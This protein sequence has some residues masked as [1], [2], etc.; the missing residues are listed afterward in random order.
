MIYLRQRIEIE[1]VSVA[2]VGFESNIGWDLSHPLPPRSAAIDLALEV[3][4]EIEVGWIEPIRGVAP[5]RARGLA[6]LSDDGESA[7]IAIRLDV[8]CT[9]K[10]SIRIRHAGRLKPNLPWRPFSAA[11]LEKTNRQAARRQLEFQT[12]LTTIRAAYDIADSA[13]RDRLRAQRD[14]TESAIEST[15]RLSEALAKFQTLVRRVREQVKLRVE[16]S[17]S[18][19]EGPQSI[20]RTTDAAVE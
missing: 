1:P 5:R 2:F 10:L 18:W 8:R 3:P 11:T 20:L 7:A 6:V 17:A 19:P 12:R 4:P 16:L 9:R 14:A 13:G 15:Q